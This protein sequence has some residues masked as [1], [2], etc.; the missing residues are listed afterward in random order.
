MV[1][2]A[3]LPRRRLGRTG[4]EAAALGVGGWLGRLDDPDAGA[5]VQEE[6]AIAAVR[7]AV[8]LGVTY[9]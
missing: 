3:G 8:E 9:F 5:A 7:R 6:T 4:L 1:M 2:K